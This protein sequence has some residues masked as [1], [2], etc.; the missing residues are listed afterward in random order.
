MPLF[1][2]TLACSRR[3]LSAPASCPILG[4]MTYRNDPESACGKLEEK[5]RLA[6]LRKLRASYRKVGNLLVLKRRIV[7]RMTGAEM[8]K[9]FWTKPTYRVLMFPIQGKKEAG[10]QRKWIAMPGPQTKM[11]QSRE[12]RPGG[13]KVFESSVAVPTFMRQSISNSGRESVHN[14]TRGL[15]GCVTVSP[16]G[17]VVVSNPAKPEGEGYGTE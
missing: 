10:L 5:Q 14:C 17:A 9:A 15:V 8:A 12:L 16:L 3:D 2:V 1:S 11:A 4:P 6:R 7:R 13:R